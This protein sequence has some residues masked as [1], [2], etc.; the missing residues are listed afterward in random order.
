MAV[1]GV[2]VFDLSEALVV[3]RWCRA[4]A[5]A[6]RSGRWGRGCPKPL[7]TKLGVSSGAV[8]A[9]WWLGGRGGLGETT[10][11]IPVNGLAQ[12]KAAAKAGA[13]GAA[14]SRH[15]YGMVLPLLFLSRPCLSPPMPAVEAGDDGPERRGEPDPWHL[16]CAAPML[17][18]HCLSCSGTCSMKH[19]ADLT[20]SQTFKVASI[21]FTRD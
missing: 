20:V 14:A 19:L 1:Q 8:A 4:M 17:C 13:P 16:P 6:A 21:S 12:A 11:T 2:S 10:V 9:S 3:E 18:H 15:T 7:L 5:A